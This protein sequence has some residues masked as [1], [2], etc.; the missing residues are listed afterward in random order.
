MENTKNT[1]GIILLV[2]ILLTFTIGG[3]FFMNYMIN[4]TT[5]KEEVK[6]NVKKELRINTSKDYIYYD[7][8]IEIMDHIFK[9]DLILNFKGL[10]YENEKLRDELEKL[11]QEKTKLSEALVDVSSCTGEWYQRKYRE[12]SDTAFGKYVSVVIKDY[13]YDCISGTIPINLKSYVININTGEIVSDE[14]L[15][16]EFNITDDKIIESVKKR[17][18]DTQVLD[19]DIQVIDING[20]LENIK[21]GTYNTNKALSIS[22]SGKLMINFVVKSNKINYNDSIEIN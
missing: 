10:E 16:N 21:N 17:L 15:L 3:Y 18:D 5:N 11:D 12:Y 7:N 22:K 1:I 6:E 8:S 4:D 2:I 13:N 20:T 9:E 19:E 14:E